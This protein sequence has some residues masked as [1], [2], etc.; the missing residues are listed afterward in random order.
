MK[1][2]K[3][4]CDKYRTSILKKQAMQIK[5]FIINA[6]TNQPF[7]GNPAGVCLLDSM[8]EEKTMQ[9][10]ASELNLSE[11]AFLHKKTTEEEYN[12]RYFTPTVEIDFCGH[13]TLASVKLLL[14]KLGLKKVELTTFKKLKISANKQGTF[15]KMQFPLYK[16]TDYKTNEKLYEAF[17][18]EKSS[19]SKFCKELDMLIIEVKDKESLLQIRPDFQ[20]ALELSTTIK[21]VVITT[22]SEDT[23]YDFY[24]RCF[25]PWIGINEDPVTGASHSVLAKYWGEKLNKQ[26]MA[27]FQLSKRGGFLNLKIVDEDKLEVY[28]NAQIVFEG[29]MNV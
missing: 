17:G 4:K 7:S 27:A 26:E 16:T 5:T 29:I 2:K 9:A 15:I 3:T 23:E 14:D 11:T 20:K 13:A 21:E 18:L 12:I 10:I 19:P 22:K 1:I 8:I 28:S 6:F 25:C 24:S